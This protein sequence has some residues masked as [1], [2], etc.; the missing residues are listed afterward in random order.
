MGEAMGSFLRV[1][2]K[3][4]AGPVGS[5]LRVFGAAVLGGLL[6]FLLNGETLRGLGFDDLE[7]WVGI[8]LTASLPILIAAVNPQDPRFGAGK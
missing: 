8:G 6:T 7:V 4:L 3:F 5:F 1:F 2:G